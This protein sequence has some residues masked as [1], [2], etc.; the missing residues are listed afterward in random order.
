MNIIQEYIQ[1]H[2]VPGNS[3]YAR[4]VDYLAQSYGGVAGILERITPSGMSTEE[5]LGDLLAYEEKSLPEWLITHQQEVLVLAY[6]L[7]VSMGYAASQLADIGMAARFHDIGKA[8]VDI[9]IIQHEGRLAPG[10]FDKIKEHIRTSNALL[11]E[12]TRASSAVLQIVLYHHEYFDGS[13]YSEG[14]GGEAIPEGARLL[15]IVD[16]FSAI[17]GARPY[18][19]HN[20][21]NMIS[22]FQEIERGRSRLYDPDMASQFIQFL[23]HSFIAWCQQKKNIAPGFGFAAPV[24]AG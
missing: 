15:S 4:F 23:H 18:P 5:Y 6:A 11:K 3:K 1:A 22:A 14:L 13:G 10:E 21:R 24:P 16:S 20:G 12:K 17:L 9:D 2:T 7:G 8:A 19:N